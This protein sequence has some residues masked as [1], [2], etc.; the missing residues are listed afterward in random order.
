MEQ[1]LGLILSAIFGAIFGSYSTLFAHRLP[2]GESCFG[3]YFGKKSHCP[4]CGSTI[5]TRELIPLINWFFTLG[6]CSKCKT[7]IPLSHLFIELSCTILF[8]LC[9]LKFSFSELFIIY[10]ISCAVCVIL[11]VTDFKNK[12]F[13]YQLLIFLAMLGIAARILIDQS[14]IDMIFSLAL[15]VVL[16]AIFY[17]IIHKKTS[18][19][20]ASATH[21]Y[22]FLKFILIVSIFLP[23][24]DFLLYFFVVI[25]IFSIMIIFNITTTK[26]NGFGYCL[27]IPFLWLIL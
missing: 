1:T 20:F 25:I 6:R 15:G 9:Y 26:K 18:G 21:F 7:K 19:L 23:I 17:Q 10:A 11:L 5:R 3:R 24:V 8:V 4:Q 2:I 16:A 27:I 14:I 22:D 13:P 12:I